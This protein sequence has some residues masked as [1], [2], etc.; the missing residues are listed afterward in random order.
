ML[1]FIFT[2][3]VKKKIEILFIIIQISYIRLRIQ[4][5][6][7]IYRFIAFFVYF[8]NHKEKLVSVSGTQRLLYIFVPAFYLDDIVERDPIEPVFLV[9]GRG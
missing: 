2:E 6:K 3:I 1:I 9:I 5:I 4:C 7:Y 8:R